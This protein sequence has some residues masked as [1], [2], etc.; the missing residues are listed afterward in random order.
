MNNI[1]K[2]IAVCTICLLP[3]G[4]SGCSEAEEEQTVVLETEEETVDYALVTVNRGD[5]VLSK[6]L[7]VTYTQTREQEVSFPVGGKRVSKVHV[8]AGDSV[9]TG[10]LLVELSAGDVEEQMDEA[11][12]RLAKDRLQLTYIDAAQDFAVEEMYNNF[13]YHTKEIGEEELEAYEKKKAELE[14]EY[15]YKREDIRDD[16]EFD[17]KQLDELRTEQHTSRIYATMDGVVYTV[18]DGLEGSTSK[19]D[20]VIMTIVDNASGLFEMKEPDYADC[21]HEGEAV[22]MSIVYGSA[23][24]EYELLPHEMNSWD[25]TQRFSLLSGPDNDGI[26]VG[27]SGTLHVTLEKKENVLTLPLAA[28]Y[29]ADGKP[30]AYILDENG[31]RQMVWISVGLTGDSLV[32]IVDGLEEGDQVVKR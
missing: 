15:E 27:T 10:D 2:C 29:Y 11:E 24:G 6:S 21:F 8:H 16:I 23:S 17:Q 1:A 14:Q 25:E 12:Y 31:F 5:V 4:L 18:T 22:P 32:E 20:A 30:Y 13:V 28:V 9:H 19:K 26:D 7:N 3:V